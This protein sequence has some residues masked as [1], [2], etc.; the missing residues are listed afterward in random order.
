MRVFEVLA[1]SRFLL[2]YDPDNLL[3]SLKHPMSFSFSNYSE[4]E[5]LIKNLIH[6]QS[7]GH[8]YD[9]STL[10]LSHRVN[11]LLSVI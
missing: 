7:I 2:S 6:S 10:L 5:S 9:T 8:N 1:H 3:S 11:F 4:L